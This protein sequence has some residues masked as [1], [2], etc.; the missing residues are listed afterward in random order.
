M[1]L[2]STL[3]IHATQPQTL[4]IVG[5]DTKVDP[6][7]EG[8]AFTQ[9]VTYFR[10]ET[11][12]LVS[13]EEMEVTNVEETFIIKPTNHDNE[14]QTKLH[15]I[16]NGT[17]KFS[18][19]RDDNAFVGVME[20][21]ISQLSYFL[22]TICI[23]QMKYEENSICEV[24]QNDPDTFFNTTI[25]SYFPDNYEHLKLPTIGN[26]GGLIQFIFNQNNQS[27]SRMAMQVDMDG[28]NAVLCVKCKWQVRRIA[29][30]S[31]SFICIP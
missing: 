31:T 19:Y 2:L 11:M 27:V 25:F 13:T 14:M 24:M 22:N 8:S 9:C 6:C 26:A 15:Y 18:P 23:E 7:G 28:S 29:D 12:P 30:P 1:L 17:E 10:N 4:S 3:L 16:V 21:T 20:V 5:S